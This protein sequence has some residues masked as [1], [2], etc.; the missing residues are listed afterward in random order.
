MSATDFLPRRDHDLL[1]WSIAYRN[2]LIATPE[3]FG[4]LPEQAVEYSA[5]HDLFAA[6]LAALVHPGMRSKP[7]F[8]AKQDARIALVKSARALARQI[9]SQPFVTDEMRVALGLNLRNTSRPRIPRPSHAPMVAIMNT[10]GRRI[11]VRVMNATGPLRR[12]RPRGVHGAMVLWS[13]GGVGGR[14]MS[15]PMA[16]SAAG[17]TSRGVLTAELPASVP[18]GSQVWVTAYW[19]NGRNE[20][21]PRAAPQTT[22]I[23]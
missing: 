1:N 10:R 17:A 12:G 23:T 16:W 11:R 9:R 15:D 5:L 13:I 8:T 4:V 3:Q 20:D 19:F 7:N 18:C 2:A 22:H 21:G 6:R 14:A